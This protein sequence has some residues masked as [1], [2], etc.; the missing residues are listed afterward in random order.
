MERNRAGMKKILFVLDIPFFFFK[1][2][3]FYS[4]NVI[5]NKRPVGLHGHLRYNQR[6]I[7][8]RLADLNFIKNIV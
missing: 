5:I 6:N 2:T 4:L 7:S 1:L 8:I 3:L